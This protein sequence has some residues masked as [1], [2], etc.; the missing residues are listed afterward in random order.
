MLMA[1]HTVGAT[2]KKGAHRSVFA[3]FDPV[4]LN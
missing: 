4:S 2:C 3:V 1:Y